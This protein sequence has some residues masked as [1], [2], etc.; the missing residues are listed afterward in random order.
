[1]VLAA[2]TALAAGKGPPPPPEP[3]PFA[4]VCDAF[5]PGYQLVPGTSTCIKIGGYVRSSVTIT[6]KPAG[7]GFVPGTGGSSG[8]APPR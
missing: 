3:D 5:G 1:M 6:D 4:K 8:K 2:G 7:G